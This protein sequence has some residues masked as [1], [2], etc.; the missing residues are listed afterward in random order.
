MLFPAWHSFPCT[1]GTG[2]AASWHLADEGCSAGPVLQAFI[3]RPLS[4]RT[5]FH[6][7]PALRRIIHFL[8]VFP[9]P[10]PR[11][12]S[13]AGGTLHVHSSWEEAAFSMPST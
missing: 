5:G 7:C 8:I 3:W 9:T 11:F 10:W 13:H 12:C 2:T 1:A 6:P 4:H